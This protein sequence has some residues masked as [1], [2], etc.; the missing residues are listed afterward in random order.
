MPVASAA[1]T[2]AQAWTYPPGRQVW[3]VAADPTTPLTA[4]ENLP[5]L[6]P[7][8]F[9]A[10]YN[11]PTARTSGVI[12]RALV[13]AAM[14]GPGPLKTNPDG[15]PRLGLD[16][17]RNLVRALLDLPHL[18]PETL[19]EIAWQAEWNDGFFQA[20]LRHPRA[21]SAAQMHLVSV[22][23][24]DALATLTQHALLPE[25]RAAAAIRRRWRHLGSAKIRAAAARVGGHGATTAEIFAGL[26]TEEWAGTVDEAVTAAVALA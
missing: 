14:S 11:N 21:D 9:W 3:E 17:E 23:P 16:E 24:H 20:Y 12:A 4:L 6:D 8:T 2:A 10:L 13:A 22:L 7:R 1:A 26:V 18:P 5:V 19:H 15:T 25:A